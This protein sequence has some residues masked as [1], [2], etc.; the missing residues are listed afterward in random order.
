MYF[1]DLVDYYSKNLFQDS[2]QTWYN[3]GASRNQHG[4]GGG[5]GF[6]MD[7]SF[8][9]YRATRDAF[10]KAASE[11]YLAT[12]A[13]EAP[14]DGVN[15]TEPDFGCT[16]DFKVAYL[17]FQLKITDWVKS[18][19]EL[20]YTYKLCRYYYDYGKTLNWQEILYSE[21]PFSNEGVNPSLAWGGTYE[22]YKDYLITTWSGGNDCRTGTSVETWG[23]FN[24]YTEAVSGITFTA[25]YG[26]SFEIADLTQKVNNFEEKMKIAMC[27]FKNFIVLTQGPITDAFDENGNFDDELFKDYNIN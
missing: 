13:A 15:P 19:I 9:T 7:D 10:L 4:C 23:I 2:S 21:E 16:P 18:S 26:T 6:F 24:P 17:D 8:A 14:Q 1:F 22:Q 5:P 12:M 25:N 3:Y 11:M 20:Y 27:S